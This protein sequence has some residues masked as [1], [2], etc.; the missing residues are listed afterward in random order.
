MSI[1]VSLYGGPGTGKS[2][3]AA[4]L[5]AELKM[6]GVNAELVQEY[7]KQ[8][9][10]ED[11]K[12]V[13][14]D[15]FYFFGKQSRKEYSLFGKVDTVVTD[16]PVSLC[17]YY[18][19]LY[20]SKEQDSLFQD[21]TKTYYN[22]AKNTGNHHVHIWL[23]RVKAYNPAGRF[24]TEEQ[25]RDIDNDMRNFLTRNVGL[26]FVEVDGSPDGVKSILEM[27]KGY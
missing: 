8:W 22:M 18:T 11:R 10:W 15:Q 20:G 19:H 6:A 13:T 2:T 14:L 16:S 24:Q 21:M 5:F 9:A 1:V 26:E 12:P 17:A 7:V 23:N 25:A 27:V 3:S 4:H